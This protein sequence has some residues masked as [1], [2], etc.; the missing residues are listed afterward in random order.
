MAGHKL[1]RPVIVAVIT[2]PM[3]QPTVY[4]VVDVVT[5]GHPLVPAVI[6]M[7]AAAGGRMAALGIPLGHLDPALV[8]VALVLLVQMP[9]MNKVDV[10]TMPNLR[11]PA[12]HRVLVGVVLMRVVLHW[13]IPPFSGQV[14]ERRLVFPCGRTVCAYFQSRRACFRPRSRFS[15]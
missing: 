13:P 6:L 5:V 12:G 9:V 11:M 10:V 8:P 15:A 3:V 7:L 2:M 1:H 14:W 4:Q